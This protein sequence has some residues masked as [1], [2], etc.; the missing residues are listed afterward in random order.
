[1]RDPDTIDTCHFG[2][3]KK[4]NVNDGTK[5]AEHTATQCL[6]HQLRLMLPARHRLKWDYFRTNGTTSML[7]LGF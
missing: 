3:I 2:F 7:E 1:M 6:Y 4:E 5:S